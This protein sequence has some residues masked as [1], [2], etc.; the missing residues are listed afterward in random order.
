MEYT[1]EEWAV[2]RKKEMAESSR[3][4]EIKRCDDLLDQCGKCKSNKA[5]HGESFTCG[6]NMCRSGRG[7]ACQACS[8]LKYVGLDGEFEKQIIAPVYPCECFEEIEMRGSDKF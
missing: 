7:Y 3:Q 5:I 8:F 4:E 2:K 6:V 1:M